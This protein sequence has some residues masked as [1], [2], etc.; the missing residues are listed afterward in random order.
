MTW[1]W[2]QE[3]QQYMLHFCMVL[4]ATSSPN[5]GI[6]HFTFELSAHYSKCENFLDMHSA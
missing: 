1:Y 6:K 5:S 4:E 2:E 3:G